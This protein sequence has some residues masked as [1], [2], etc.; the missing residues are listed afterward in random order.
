MHITCMRL[1]GDEDAASGQLV[2]GEDAASGQLGQTRQSSSALKENFDYRGGE[3]VPLQNE[4]APVR[5][6]LRPGTE[7]PRLLR[8]KNSN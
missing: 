5:K 3:H 1:L 2:N 7:H 4:W 6:G 8:N